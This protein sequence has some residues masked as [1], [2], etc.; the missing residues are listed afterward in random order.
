MY[1]H[2]NLRQL[3]E[4]CHPVL[5]GTVTHGVSLSQLLSPGSC[6]AQQPFPAPCQALQLPHDLVPV[7]GLGRLRDPVALGLDHLH[8]GFAIVQEALEQLWGGRGRG[9]SYQI[10]AAEPN[11][12]PW[13]G[14]IS[15]CGSEPPPALG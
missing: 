11:P 9:E 1:P 4:R 15:N 2:Q 3:P 7:R 10:G 14:Q 13:R 12:S 6:P 5:R 8:R